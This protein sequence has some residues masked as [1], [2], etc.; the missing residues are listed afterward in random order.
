MAIDAYT[1]LLLHC[2]GADASTTFTD[3]EL[4]PKTVTAVGNAQIDT[5]Q[6]KFGGAA[7][8]FD[9]TG[10]YLTT[11]DHADWAF[12]TGNFTIDC[13]VRFASVAVGQTICA[14]W[15]DNSYYWSYYWNSNL[16]IFQQK[17]TTL[18]INLSAA[19]TP[20]TNTWYHIALT[21]SG[22][23]WRWFVNGTQVGADATEAD[24][25]GD[26]TSVLYIGNTGIS[27]YEYYFNGWIDELRI[28]KGIARW[29]ANFAPPNYAYGFNAGGFSLFM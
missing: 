11:P 18:N 24:S 4:T 9:G 16:L 28:S 25:V 8:L 15:Q 26:I 27:G 3:S 6:S 29:T 17:S 13:W 5:A 2:N 21:R 23:T 12:G 10:D 20:L 7:G 22:N 14:Q 1:K 19:W